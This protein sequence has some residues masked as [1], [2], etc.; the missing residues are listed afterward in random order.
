MMIMGSGPSNIT[1]TTVNPLQQA[2]QPFLLQGW[3]QAK[4]L[5][6]QFPQN[7]TPNQTLAENNPGQVQ[8]YSNIFG[9]GQSLDTG[10]RPNANRVFTDA[11][12]GQYGY[13]N[14]PATPYYQD[15]STG[16]SDPQQ[17]LQELMGL[18]R[19]IGDSAQ[20]TIGG[21]A[22]TA[23]G[24]G[25]K[26]AA[27]GGNFEDQLAATARGD[28]LTAGGKNPYLSDYIKMA[29]DPTGRQFRSD[30][31]ALDADMVKAGRYGSGALLGQRDRLEQNYG[32]ALG[33]IATD[34]S[35]RNYGDERARQTAAAQQG[36]DLR[37]RGL[38]TGITGAS[39][40]AGIGRDA[41]NS[42]LSGYKQAGDLAGADLTARGLG[43]GGL[44]HGYDAGT[45]ASLEAMRNYP[46]LANAQ[47]I[48]A[49][50]DIQ[51]GAGQRTL[52]QQ[53]IDDTNKRFYGEQNAPFDALTRYLQQINGQGA[54]SGSQSVSSPNFQNTGANVLSAL[55]GITSLLG[56]NGLNVLGGS[57]AAS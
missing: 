48:A 3:N 9:T 23:A 57:G 18:S 38:A 8:G 17:R 31:A 44:A 24:Y 53:K 56:K 7:Y 29:Q 41:L 20:S 2:Q 50:N 10:L 43:A 45:Q 54:I 28:Y 21:Y 39:T 47:Y 34:I 30:T 15:F 19:G 37:N 51:A 46:Q 52:E 22:P 26:A 40:A 55:T 1:Q 13:Q 36:W 33:K 42:M 32:D 6:E 49:N 35:Y 27:G 14:S 5:Y 16:S 12:A 11:A 25:A 4:N